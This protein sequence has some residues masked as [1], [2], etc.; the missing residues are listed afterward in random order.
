VPTAKFL[1]PSTAARRYEEYRSEMFNRHAAA[2][3]VASTPAVP[4]SISPT[5]I[6]MVAVAAP[7]PA[8]RE[9]PTSST[10]LT[11]CWH[12]RCT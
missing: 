11:T 10:G 1:K 5:T 4:E 9:V 12:R 6:A 3:A 7:R 2:R 8:G